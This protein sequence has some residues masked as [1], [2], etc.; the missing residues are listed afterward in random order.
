[1]SDR[2][3]LR[4]LS[5]PTKVSILGLEV[6]TGT[7]SSSDLAE[8]LEILSSD[9]SERT[10]LARS[11]IDSLAADGMPKGRL[12]DLRVAFGL[13]DTTS[14][15]A[16][17]PQA[18]A[19]P[20]A[21]AEPAP[22]ASPPQ[23][24]RSRRSGV[25]DTRMVK[26]AFRAQF[27]DSV[28]VSQARAAAAAAG[29]ASERPPCG[30]SGVLHRILVADEDDSVRSAIRT[31]LQ[32]VGCYVFEAGDGNEAWRRLETPGVSAVVMD[33]KLSGISG[34]DL[35]A[36]L[37]SSGRALPVVV[38]T[39]LTGMKDEFAV[40]TYP[41]LRFLAKPVRTRVLFQAL[42]ELLKADAG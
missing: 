2:E 40:T 7:L 41:R 33:M 34:L 26:L 4:R 32:S 13:T 29:G 17:K 20:A 11:V 35:L 19:A 28:A 23:T 5:R 36:R 42:C 18:P 10:G 15:P 1:M 25:M 8:L 12:T 14:M 37:K 31:E 3:L 24:E 27:E 9:P 16:V 6:K 21:P 22:P 39:E 30:E 38:C